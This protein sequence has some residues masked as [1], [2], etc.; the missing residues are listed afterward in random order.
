M[1]PVVRAWVATPLSQL[2]GYRLAVLRFSGRKSGRAYR[3]PV[4]LHDVG[5]G[6]GVFTSEVWR[7]NFRGGAPVR[8]KAGGRS[9]EATGTLVEDPEEVARAM[10][11]AIDSGSSLTLLG[12]EV[13]QG[14]RITADDV[15]GLRDMVRVSGGGR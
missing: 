15:R 11:H 14:H 9:F 6:K 2:A 7:L 1:N 8:V 13:D 3:V 12:L 5:D 10:Q 4:G